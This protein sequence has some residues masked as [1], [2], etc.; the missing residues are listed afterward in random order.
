MLR[1]RRARHLGCPSCRSR[2]PSCPRAEG[3]RTNAVCSGPIALAAGKTNADRSGAVVLV[4]GGTRGP[5]RLNLKSNLKT[6]ICSEVW[7]WLG[8]CTIQRERVRGSMDVQGG[9]RFGRSRPFVLGGEAC[10]SFASDG[11]GRQRD[12]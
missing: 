8:R 7:C 12:R 9:S 2:R 6:I 10:A 11:G 1:R 4:V 3:W 5:I